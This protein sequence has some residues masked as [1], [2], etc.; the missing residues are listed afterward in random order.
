MIYNKLVTKLKLINSLLKGDLFILVVDSIMHIGNQ[1]NDLKNYIIPTKPSNS[2]VNNPFG[3]GALNN[4]VEL[5]ALNV[6]EGGNFTWTKD[7]IYTENLLHDRPIYVMGPI[8]LYELVSKKRGMHTYI[9]GDEHTI[10]PACSTNSPTMI[11]IVDF[12]KFVIDENQDK[13]IDVFLEDTYQDP[14]K[15]RY[16]AIGHTYLNNVMFAFKDCLQGNRINCPD[17]KTRFHYGDIRS[18]GILEK[19]YAIAYRHRDIG[20]EQMK[21]RDVFY[22]TIDDVI[23]D[24]R[25]FDNEVISQET[26][27]TKQL[28]NIDDFELRQSISTYFNKQIA[29][30]VDKIKFW[31]RQT[32]TNNELFREKHYIS[33]YIWF[34]LWSGKWV[35]YYTV[36]RM[37][38]SYK[39]SRSGYSK[40]P[41]KN[42]LYYMGGEHTRNIVKF[43]TTLDFELVSV[44]KSD[45]KGENFQCL[46]LE[47]KYPFFSEIK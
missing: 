38:R 31:Y 22:A 29:E 16:R 35:D 8:S 40:V 37:F 4:S 27:I 32:K 2:A 43:L 3:T 19:V 33:T 47:A 39:V 34:V 12:I 44:S 14:T 36:A 15:E 17:R 18:L 6:R 25:T 7:M 11:H 20:H 28:A 42:I 46:K 26:R 10:L 24:K 45:V 13:T 1:L 30:D 23:N 41:A 5:G 9:F 21:D